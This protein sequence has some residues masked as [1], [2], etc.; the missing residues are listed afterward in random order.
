MPLLNKR[1]RENEK[2]GR[3][4]AKKSGKSSTTGPTVS[5]RHGSS[6]KECGLYVDVKIQGKIA[7]PLADTG[8]TVTLV[9][10]SSYKKLCA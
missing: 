3:N 10:E 4:N 6:I 8:A 9:S 1:P 2:S 5:V 7:R